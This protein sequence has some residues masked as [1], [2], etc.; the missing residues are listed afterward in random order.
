MLYVEG[1]GEEPSIWFEK[2]REQY[3]RIGDAAGTAHALLKLADQHWVDARTKESLSAAAE[4]ARLL[5]ERGDRT[6]LARAYL[7][8][9]RFSATLGDDVAARSYLAR[10]EALDETFDGEMRSSYHEIR[11]E[12]QAALGD[13][14][15]AL[16]DCDTAASHA[17]VAGDSE[18]IAQVEN[19]FALVAADVGE[20]TIAIRRHEKAL[21]EA[22]RTRMLWRVAYCALNYA[23]TRALC[24]ELEAARRLAWEALEC[25]VTTKTFQ[26]KAAAVGIPLALRLNDRALLE[27]CTFETAVDSARSSGELQRIGGVC[28]AFAELSAARGVRAE[29][30]ALLRESLAALTHD[31][32]CWHALEAIA[33]MG[34]PSDARNARAILEAGGG[35]PSLV[36][37]RRALLYAYEMRVAN[38]EASGR[39]AR[40]AARGFARFGFALDE[41][42]A[43][44]LA[45]DRERA[46][47]I[48]RRCGSLADLAGLERAAEPEFQVRELSPRQL[49]IAQ[50]VAQ[51]ETNKRIAAALH[52]SEHTVEHHVSAIFERLGVKTRASLAAR[53]ARR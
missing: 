36:R 27:A 16:R 18:T 50:L 28:A 13:F 25:G 22:R 19:N 35:R 3:A 38:P 9:A 45:G 4:A 44:E 17:A 24:G 51:G 40:A 8:L 46:A 34:D 41:A 53:V 49:E 11:S 12:T 23:Q 42:A 39:F 47:G 43:Y 29:G 7:S 14:R 10:C 6:A 21:R 20:L 2:S 33:R 31:H 48:Y 15:A 1:C 26:T 5:T 30:L 52:I 37:A 32:R